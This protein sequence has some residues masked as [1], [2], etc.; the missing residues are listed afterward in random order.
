MIGITGI[1]GSEATRSHEAFS[2]HLQAH[3]PFILHY[4]NCGF[5]FWLDKF[6]LLGKFHDGYMRRFT[7]PWDSMRG[8]RDVVLGGK[9]HAD[10]DDLDA[11]EF[12]S[13]EARAFYTKNFV[14]GKKCEARRRSQNLILD[15]DVAA[16]A[17][18]LAGETHPLGSD[19]REWIDTC[20][21]LY[22]GD[23]GHASAAIG[24]NGDSESG[25]TDDDFEFL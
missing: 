8:S 17:K 7:I 19:Q 18:V 6:I 1:M 15:I 9:E 2:P 25:D 4:V 3:G 10:G 14:C 12:D 11:N 23:R 16:R 5:P 24:A 13:P 22:G 21:G 20:G